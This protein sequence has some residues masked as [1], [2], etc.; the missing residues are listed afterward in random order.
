M[1]DNVNVEPILM[2]SASIDVWRTLPKGNLILPAG[3]RLEL[4]SGLRSICITNVYRGGGQ[5]PN[6]RST[7]STSHP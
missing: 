6:S 5:T 4:E 1:M 3:Q 2:I 7:S